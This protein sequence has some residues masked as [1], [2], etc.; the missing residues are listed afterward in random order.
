MP[1]LKTTAVVLAVVVAGMS[2]Y[3]IISSYLE[4]HRASQAYDSIR[5]EAVKV[6]EPAAEPEEA[7]RT[8]NYIDVDFSALESINPDIVAWLYIHETPVSYP[9]LMGPDN[10]MYLSTTYD[11]KPNVLGSIF[12]DYRNDPGFSDANTIIYGHNTRNDAMFGCLKRYKDQEYADAHP[13]IC[14][15]K[16]NG[17]NVYEIFT[18]YETPATSNTYTIRFSSDETFADYIRDMRAQSIVAAADPPKGEN[19]VTLSTCTGGEKIMRLVIQAKHIDFVPARV[20]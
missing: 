20:K 16:E 18:I 1:K 3:T 15:I 7:R 14:I 4:E 5:G 11:R 19:I 10:Q 12:Q 13:E 8:Y 9:V 17:V 6:V 2:G